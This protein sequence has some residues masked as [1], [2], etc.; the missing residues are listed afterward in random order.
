MSYEVTQAE[1]AQAEKAIIAFNHSLALLHQ[2]SDHLNIMLTPF[3]DHPDIST[4]E[5]INFR[6][7]LRRF[8]DKSIENFNNFKIASFKCITLMQLFSSDTQTAKL[9]KSFISSVEDIET[10]VNVFAELFDNLESKD[11]VAQVV[12]IIEGIKKETDQLEQI[13][14]DRIKSHIQ[15]NIL[16][17]TWV[18][19]VS[20]ELQINVEKK[21]PLLVELHKER[22][23]QL[24]NLS[25]EREKK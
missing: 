23:N 3:K 21:V 7:A 15:T 9:I 25:K 19:S 2:A 5:I 14:D 17:K 16:G 20:D 6:A 8:R 13:I 24:N 12:K 4:E 11:F 1:K 18:D 10:Q 22:Q